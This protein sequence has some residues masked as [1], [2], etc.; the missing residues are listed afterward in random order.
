CLMFKLDRKFSPYFW[1]NINSP[2]IAMPGIIEYT[3]L[4]PLNHQDHI[5]YVPYYMPQTH[6]KYQ[7]SNEQ[8]YTE[9]ISAF[10]KIR[11]DFEISWI[12]AF[13]LSRYFYAQPV[14]EC[15]YLEKLPPMKSAIEG[16]FMADTSYY[17][18]QDRC[19]TES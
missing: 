16:F 13:Q 17:Y 11:P 3:N 4:N 5:L 8:F 2:D 6:P 9:V 15:G 19:I 14:C 12:K 10:K 18:P 7:W 1:L